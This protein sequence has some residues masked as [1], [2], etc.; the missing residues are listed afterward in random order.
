[1]IKANNPDEALIRYAK[2]YY[3][4]DE[5]FKESIEDRAINMT[6]WET[7]FSP[8][9]NFED[10]DIRIDP[11]G[12]ILTDLSD[13]E[14]KMKFK[15]N[16][17]DYLGEYKRFASNLI[18]FYKDANKKFDELPAELI[19]YIALKEMEEDREFIIIKEL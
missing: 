18:D 11:D 19:E 12:K 5:F 8:I 3:A 17:E 6:F 2:E 13:D 9:F 7:F 1:M 4:K 14:I 10:C 16:I 15:E